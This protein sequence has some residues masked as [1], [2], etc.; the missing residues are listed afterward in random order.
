M[1]GC[2][3]RGTVKYKA[4]TFSDR[5]STGISFL[6]NFRNCA[7]KLVFCVSLYEII[8]FFVVFFDIKK[9]MNIMHAKM[10][11]IFPIKITHIMV[12]KIKVK[13]K[14]CFKHI[15]RIVFSIQ[16]G[17]RNKTSPFHSV[18]DDVYENNLENSQP[19]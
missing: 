4:K 18:K 6:L 9:R 12:C 16:S 15:L 13:E 2:N 11:S 10:Q 5:I 19:I 1:S 3:I 14:T 8:F 17:Y 7:V